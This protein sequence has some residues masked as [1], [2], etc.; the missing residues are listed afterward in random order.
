MAAS[1]RKN[2][3]CWS[4]SGRKSV[5]QRFDSAAP[6]PLGRNFFHHGAPAWSYLEAAGEGRFPRVFGALGF[7]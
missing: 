6:V 1:D 3:R 7:G 4:R 2:G 5:F